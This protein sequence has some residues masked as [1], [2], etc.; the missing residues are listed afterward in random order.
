MTQK[1]DHFE[2]VEYLFTLTMIFY[3]LNNLTQ[4]TNILQFQ[5][6]KAMKRGY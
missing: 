5:I 4:N 3:T 6:K 2:I 1:Y